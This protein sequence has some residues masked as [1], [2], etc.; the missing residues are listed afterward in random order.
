MRSGEA[1]AVEHSDLVLEFT[2]LFQVWSY[3]V[4]H[5]QL[6]LRSTKHKSRA[7]QTDVLFK[8]VALMQLATQYDDLRIAKVLPLRLP[9][10]AVGA[11]IDHNY[12]RLTGSNGVG[13]VVAG[14]VIS[15]ESDREYYESSSLVDATEADAHR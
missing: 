10:I 13:L 6:L 3:T 1:M 12:Y 7:T 9:E 14:T 2:G 4:S 15:N 5:G 8:N 11:V